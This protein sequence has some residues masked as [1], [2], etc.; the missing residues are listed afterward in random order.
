MREFTYKKFELGSEL[1]Q[2]QQDF[3]EKWGFIHFKNFISK[4]KVA[5]IIKGAESVQTKW[6]AENRELVNGVP[7][8]YGRDID[9]TKIVQRYAFASLFS[10]VLHDFLK[11]ERF[12]SLFP[13]LGKKVLNPRVGEYEKD[14]LVLNHYINSEFSTFSQMGWHTDSLR[15]VFY[16]KKIMPMLNVGVHLDNCSPANGGLR[17]IPSTHKQTLRKL[18]FRKKYFLDY[19]PD[20]EEIGLTVEAGDLTVHDGRLWHRVALSELTGEISRRRVMYVPFITGKFKP[21]NE[22]SKPRFYQRFMYLLK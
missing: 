5:D 22:K 6:I 8:K 13:L 7:V 19:E 15:D 1:T 20:P 10:P 21:R 11:D 9:G 17:L 16:G 18:L 14:G 3:F 12:K 2:E 4:E